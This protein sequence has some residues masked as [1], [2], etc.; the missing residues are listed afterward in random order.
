[1]IVSFDQDVFRAPYELHVSTLVR[2]SFVGLKTIEIE[3][4]NKHYN[5]VQAYYLS[6]AKYKRLSEIP[7][8]FKLDST[9]FKVEKKIVIGNGREICISN[10]LK[11]RESIV[12]VEIHVKD[13]RVENFLSSCVSKRVYSSLFIAT[14][15]KLKEREIVDLI[16]THGLENTNFYIE[17][18]LYDNNPE[19]EKEW[20]LSYV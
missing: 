13:Q 11:I 3:N 15:R 12:G 19:F 2:K 10:S 14:T 1:M 4:F 6:S 16:R 7:I 20:L 9:R 18:V 5:R 17:Y 8:I